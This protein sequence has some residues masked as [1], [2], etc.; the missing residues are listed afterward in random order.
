MARKKKDD[1]AGESGFE[2]RIPLESRLLADRLQKISKATGLSD[3]E[4]LQKWVIQEESN[5]HALQHYVGEKLGQSND[6]SGEPQ[7]VQK[8]RKKTSQLQE[9]PESTG[10][11]EAADY[12]Q[13]L[14]QRIQRMRQQGM[15]INQIASQFNEEGVATVSGTGKWY[16][17]S[18][19][20]ILAT[21]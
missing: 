14:L 11:D 15:T 6:Q 20:H 18:I 19:S 12:R 3:Q 16:Y 5:L 7:R 8:P 1:A 4:L 17:S 21:S 2:I 10:S 13:T 9:T